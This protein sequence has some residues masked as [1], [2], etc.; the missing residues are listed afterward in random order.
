MLALVAVMV[1]SCGQKGFNVDGTIKGLEGKV[2]LVTMEGKER[3][4]ADSTTADA[5]GKFKFAGQLEM[6]ILAAIASEDKKNVAVFMLENSNIVL[7]SDLTPESTLVVTGSVEDSVFR[8]YHTSMRAKKISSMEEY[9][10]A[11]TEFIE[12]N[13]TRVAAAYSLFAELSPSLDY[14]ELGDY[15]SKMD[16][17]LKNS[18]YI[19]KV[20]ER[21]VT[22]A[23]TAIGQPFIDFSAPNTAGDTVAL[24]DVAGKGKWVL[25]DFWAAWC[26]PCRAENPHLVAA[27]DEY[28]DKGFTVF[29]YSLDGEG[30]HSEWIE[31]IAKDKLTWTNISDLKGWTSAPAQ[32]YGVNSIPSS[33]MISPDG[34]IAA[35]NLRGNALIEF[36]RENVK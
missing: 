1:A 32:V 28:K 13:P 6:P 19:K 35:K 33:V 2:Y 27:F 17:S 10:A 9:K 20:E 11:I 14:A 7:V 29:G 36:L 12:A 23:K 8:A 5:E 34:I 22:M 24:S 30:K 3:V 25:L 26:P 15:L 31:A 4:Y 18:I 16:S 21:L